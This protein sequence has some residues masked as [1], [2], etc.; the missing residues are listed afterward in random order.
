[1]LHAEVG[2]DWTERDAFP[3]D[4][5]LNRLMRDMLHAVA[6]VGTD[7]TKCDASGN[8]TPLNRSVFDE[9]HVTRRVWH[10]LGYKRRIS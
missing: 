8:E 6:E 5:T 1:M 2:M 10:G 3:N 7:W 9:R 4:T